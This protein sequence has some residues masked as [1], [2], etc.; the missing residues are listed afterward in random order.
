MTPRRIARSP[1]VAGQIDVLFVDLGPMLPQIK[2]GRPRARHHQQQ[3]VPDRAGDQAA[4]VPR[5]TLPAELA[6]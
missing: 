3:A 4:P 1:L 2:A 6:V 5:R